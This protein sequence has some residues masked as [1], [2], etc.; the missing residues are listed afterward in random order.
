MINTIMK[1]NLICKNTIIKSESF[2]LKYCYVCKKLKADSCKD[3]HIKYS[4]T[5][6]KSSS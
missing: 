3:L 6:K 1:T 5:Y 4:S 2:E